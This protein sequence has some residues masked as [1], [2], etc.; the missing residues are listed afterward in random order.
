MGDISEMRGLVTVVT[1]LGVVVLLIAFI[2]NQFYTASGARNVNVPDV[3]EGI[4]I[5]SFAESK[6]I[7]LNETGGS[8]WWAD[9]N[10]YH[11]DI[12]IGSRNFD[13]YYKRANKTNLNL[14]VIHIWYEW[15][16][17]PYDHRLT[18]YNYQGIEKGDYLLVSYL[19]EDGEDGKARYNIECSHFRAYSQLAYNNTLYSSFEDA[20]NN[21]GLYAFFGIDF[22]QVNT[23]YNAFA[24]LGML[25]FWQL[26]EVHWIVNILLS[27]P[28]WICIAYLTFILILRA[29]GAIFGGGA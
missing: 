13:L 19:E 4:D 11:V 6:M 25:L 14:F 29:I 16:F 27:I 20:W 5:Y 2:P 22:D 28:L 1:F 8:I 18:W 9:S 15:I 24:L 21:H 17:I 3:F 7:G 12:D 10:Y 26:P 23:S